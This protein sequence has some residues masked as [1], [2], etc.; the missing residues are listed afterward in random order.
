MHGSWRLPGFVTTRCAPG[1]R[2]PI[3]S[4]QP[5]P[6]AI[7]FSS[8]R[9][10]DATR[11]HSGLRPATRSSAVTS[12]APRI[13]LVPMPLPFG[14]SAEILMSSPP[15]EKSNFVTVSALL[16]SA[17]QSCG[18]FGARISASDFRTPDCPRSTLSTRT[19]FAASRLTRTLTGFTP[20]SVT[21][22]LK[23]A[24]PIL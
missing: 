12:A 17:H 8:A 3:W 24:P 11:F 21:A 1:T 7:S 4:C 23:T 15:R 19:S 5:P 13:E 14:T 22:A 9:V 10:S 16:T 20:F 18:S 6:V 2:P